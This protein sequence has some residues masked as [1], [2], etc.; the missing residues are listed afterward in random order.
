MLAFCK[1][2]KINNKVNMY[3][4]YIFKEFLLYSIPLHLAKTFVQYCSH[5]HICT[6]LFTIGFRNRFFFLKFCSKLIINTFALFS[7]DQLKV[8]PSVY[9][10]LDPILFINLKK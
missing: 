4:V 6:L 8:C 7:S 1:L 10:Y 2:V 9:Y 5:T 3:T